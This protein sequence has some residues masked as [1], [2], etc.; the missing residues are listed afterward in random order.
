[1]NRAP[2]VDLVI[3]ADASP[4]LGMGHVVRTLALA[5]QWRDS[6][7]YPVLLTQRNEPRGRALAERAGITWCVLTEGCDTAQM[8]LQ[9]CA[10]AN[11]QHLPR[12]PAW[13]VWDVPQLARERVHEWQA[14]G[15]RVA[16]IEDSPSAG[17]AAAQLLINP[18]PGAQ[19]EDLPPAPG[20]RRLLG[21]D[22][23]MLQASADAASRASR[24]CAEVAQRV[25]ITMGAADP[26]QLTEAA[27]ALLGEQMDRN[28]EIQVVAGPLFA[29]ERVAALAAN[30]GSRATLLVAPESLRAAIEWADVAIL[31]GGN[32]LWEACYAG[33]PVASFAHNELQARILRR[34]DSKGELL[35]LGCATDLDASA[36]ARTLQSMLTSTELRRSLSRRGQQLIDGR[37]AERIVAELR[38]TLA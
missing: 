4:T 35:F 33:C 2:Q 13:V 32:T 6:G 31:C 38:R 3:R 1:M 14:F 17:G 11:V 10:D 36:A 21:T 24:T 30:L 20:Q 37:G 19:D 22:Y 28:V 16:V 26:M 25:L 7:G 27:L 9:H 15:F 8:W 5:K 23:V 29:R 12:P 18:N 34:M